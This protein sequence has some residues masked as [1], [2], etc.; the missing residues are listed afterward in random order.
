MKFYII[1]LTIILF[2][3]NTKIL[4]EVPDHR[5]NCGKMPNKDNLEYIEDGFKIKIKDGDIGKCDTDRKPFKG[6]TY[7]K[8]YSERAEVV[9]KKNFEKKKTHIIKFK[10]KVLQGY[11]N[12]DRNESWFQIKCNSSSKVPV[13]AFFSGN[14]YQP[15][16]FALAAGTKHNMYIQK[17]SPIKLDYNQWI[18]VEIIFNNNNP[19]EIGVKLNDLQ[20]LEKTS[21]KQIKSCSKKY[22]LR[23]GIYRGGKTSE[24]KL[25]TSEIIYK[26]I[27]FDE[28]KL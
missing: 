9:F 7:Y 15:F 18:N 13:M 3:F 1:I 27:I 17:M 12:G 25:V 11:T 4:A 26:D 8:P 6:K 28:L 23:L 14:R 24:E 5:I 22:S 21:F 16:S 10:M 19:T 2:N 20:L